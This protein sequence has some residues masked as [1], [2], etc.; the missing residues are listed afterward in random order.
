MEEGQR[1]IKACLKEAGLSNEV[2]RLKDKK[3]HTD[4]V[5]DI[6]YIYILAHNKFCEKLL[7]L[8]TF[9]TSFSRIVT[10]PGAISIVL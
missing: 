6:K 10:S 8:F 5:T 2:F 4:G 3:K 1:I 9:T 7:Y